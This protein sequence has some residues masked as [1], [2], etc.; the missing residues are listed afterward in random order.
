MGSAATAGEDGSG[1]GTAVSA[2]CVSVADAEG[3][4]GDKD[5]FEDSAGSGVSGGDREASLADAEAEDDEDEDEL[6]ML[7]ARRLRL[8][9]DSID[10][11]VRGRLHAALRRRSR[12]ACVGESLITCSR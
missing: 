2:S 4:I 3:N 9:S 5:L 7:S 6:R 10:C 1:G 11:V 8:A 12:D